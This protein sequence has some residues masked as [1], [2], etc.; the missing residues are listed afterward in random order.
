M[1]SD[2][3]KY[4]KV[5]ELIDQ[6]FEANGVKFD[7]KNTL[8]LFALTHFFIEYGIT[9]IVTEEPHF[10]TRPYSYRVITGVVNKTSSSDFKRYDSYSKAHAKAILSALRILNAQIQPATFV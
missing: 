10:N 4:E 7:P 3:Q 2:L 5:R 8:H 6:H 1:Q 9:L